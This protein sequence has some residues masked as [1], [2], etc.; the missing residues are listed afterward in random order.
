MTVHLHDES[1]GLMYN[2]TANITTLSDGRRR[3]VARFSGVPEDKHYQATSK[4]YYDQF[5]QHS[6]PTETSEC[7]YSTVD[8]NNNCTTIQTHL[9]FCM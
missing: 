3:L 7:Q 8:I 5:I 9:T 6:I 2:T 1:S 4:V